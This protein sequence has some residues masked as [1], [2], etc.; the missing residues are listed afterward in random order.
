MDREYVTRKTYRFTML[1]FVLFMALYSV[2]AAGILSQ[3]IPSSSY[4]ALKQTASED[5]PASVKA[6]A[7]A[8]E[9]TPEQAD[10]KLMFSDTPLYR[11]APYGEIIGVYDADG[12][13]VG[14]IDV[15]LASLPKADTAYINEGILLYSEDELDRLICDYT[16]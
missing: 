15:K 12:K 16:G 3:I 13:L 8:Q 9:D 7:P 10:A 11:I 6:P 14:E 2:T 4:E 5:L 1:A